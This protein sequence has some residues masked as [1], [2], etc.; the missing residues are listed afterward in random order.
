MLDNY[1]NKRMN[2]LVIQMPILLYNVIF[3]LVYSKQSNSCDLIKSVLSDLIGKYYE[4]S[5]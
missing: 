1:L 2:L 5:F 3:F 4:P